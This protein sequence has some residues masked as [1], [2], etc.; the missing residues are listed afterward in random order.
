MVDFEFPSTRM[1]EAC[2]GKVENIL[3]LVV[4]QVT[5]E[6]ELQELRN[7]LIE[8]RRRAHVEEK[9]ILE[10]IQDDHIKRVVHREMEIFKQD[11][12]IKQLREAVAEL[13]TRLTTTENELVETRNELKQ[14]QNELVQTRYE[15]KQTQNELVQTRNELAELRETV[16]QFIISKKR[17]S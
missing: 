2:I 1:F 14:T 9:R 15:L 12:V 3:R 6:S 10:E 13:Q 8:N 11:H 16:N 7:E 17:R 5:V 4:G